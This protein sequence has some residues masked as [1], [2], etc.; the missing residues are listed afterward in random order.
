MKLNKAEWELLLKL[1]RYELQVRDSVLEDMEGTATE[2]VLRQ[3]AE[4]CDLRRKLFR[5][6]HGCDF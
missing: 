5:K 4:L 2:D 6:V 1:V 3:H